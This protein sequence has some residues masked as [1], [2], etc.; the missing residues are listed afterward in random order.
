MIF[1]TLQTPAIVVYNAMQY[2]I[3]LLDADV[4][5]PFFLLTGKTMQDRIFG[6]WLKQHGR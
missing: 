3:I 1:R 6:K 2:L 5:L 4:D